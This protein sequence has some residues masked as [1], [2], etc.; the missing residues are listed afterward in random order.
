[1]VDDA[2]DDWAREI[3]NSDELSAEI[4]ELSEE[5]LR[6]IGAEY[7]D[8][9][10]EAGNSDEEVLLAAQGDREIRL[11]ASG[12]VS[13]TGDGAGGEEV[14]FSERIVIIDSD[15]DDGSRTEREF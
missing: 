3:K 2:I 7:L 4:R 10:L 11:V 8:R 13:A 5:S 6:Q 1:M 14:S 9:F 15:K 12:E